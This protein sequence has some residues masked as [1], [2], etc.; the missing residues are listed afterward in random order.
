MNETA[1]IT[2]KVRMLAFTERRSFIKTAQHKLWSQAGEV[3]PFTSVIGHRLNISIVNCR[4]VT[5][6]LL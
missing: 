2:L 3:A 1:S 6:G 4:V 5:K